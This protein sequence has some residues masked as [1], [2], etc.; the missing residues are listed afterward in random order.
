M[1]DYATNL[2]FF[3]LEQTGSVC[4]RWDGRMTAKAQ[5]ELF[6]RFL[7]KGRITIDGA[8][9]RVKMTVKVCFGLDWDTREDIAWKDLD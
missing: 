3:L 5:R 6:G 9:E 7:G 4:G 1:T 8:H 2:A